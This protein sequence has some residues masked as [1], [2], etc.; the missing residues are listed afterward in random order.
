VFRIRV[1]VDVRIRAFCAPIGEV[2]IA[3]F[4][5]AFATFPLIVVDGVAVFHQFQASVLALLHRSVPRLIAG[6]VVFPLVELSA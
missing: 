6:M 1:G 3:P 2:T 4:K 5:S